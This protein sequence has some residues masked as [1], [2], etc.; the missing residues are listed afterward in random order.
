MFRQLLAAVLI[1]HATS[2]FAQNVPAEGEVYSSPISEMPEQDRLN[3]LQEM[4]DHGVSTGASFLSS[5]GDDQKT[6]PIGSQTW[7]CH[8][9]KR[10]NYDNPGLCNG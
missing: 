6:C 9:S 10:C 3:L 7:C 5:C 8:Q 2:S 1:L 4:L